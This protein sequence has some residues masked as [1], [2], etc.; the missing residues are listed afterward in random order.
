MGGSAW[1]ADPLCNGA[2]GKGT[3]NCRKCTCKVLA[4][5]AARTHQPLV[6]VLDPTLRAARHGRGLHQPAAS[7][8]QGQRTVAP[9]EG[10]ASLKCVRTC[11]AS[12]PSLMCGSSSP[13]NQPRASPRL[14]RTT[15]AVLCA[16][17]L[18]PH[19]LALLQVPGRLLVESDIGP[20]LK[21][22]HAELWWPDDAS[23]YLIEI[24]V[25]KREHWGDAF[26]AGMRVC[27]LA[28]AGL[29]K[30]TPGLCCSHR[31]HTGRGHGQQG[32]QDRVHH[33]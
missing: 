7:Q 12:A 14:W 33:R 27:V 18:H 24:Q 25:S 21:G 17:T 15:T 11:C 29:D 31:G 9:G 23:W 13:Y 2:R 8:P 22:R 6:S 20:A 4:P 32:G 16:S 26:V 28:A 5:P 1:L 10:S 3:G 30:V 19:S